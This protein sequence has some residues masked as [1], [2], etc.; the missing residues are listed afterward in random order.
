MTGDVGIQL[1][2]G[3]SLT[4]RFGQFGVQPVRFRLAP[5]ASEDH[6]LPFS[7]IDFAVRHS[8]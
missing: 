7:F 4:L 1:R 8:A 3:S 2:I 6:H 5:I